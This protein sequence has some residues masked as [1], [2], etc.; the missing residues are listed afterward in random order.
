[1]NTINHNMPAL[2][3][4]NSYTINQE[5]TSH[6]LRKLSSGLKINGARD[7]AALLAISEKMRS[8]TG[9]L[10]RSISNAYDGRNLVQTA[11]GA[12]NQTHS[13][14]QRMRELAVQAANGT[15][16][17][18]DRQQLQ[19]EARQLVGEIDRISDDTEFNTLKLLN[20]SFEKTATADTDSLY[21]AK[22]QLDP[23]SGLATGNYS[24]A[25]SGADAAQAT[26]AVTDRS[27]VISGAGSSFNGGDVTLKDGAAFGSYSLEVTGNGDGTYNGTLTGPDG[28][29]VR[30][31]FSAGAGGA[32]VDF[33]DLSLDFSGVTGL[34]DGSLEI[35]VTGNL[36]FTVAN[37]STGDVSD[38]AFNGYSGGAINLGG[39]QLTGGVRAQ[40]AGASGD[41]GVAVSG[42][43]L[44]LH[45]GANEGQNVRVSLANTSSVSLGVNTVD[46]RTQESANAA[47]GAI[48]EAINKISTERSRMGSATNRM[49]H[50]IRSLAAAET[51]MT[52]SESRIRDADMAKEILDHTKNNILAQASLSIMAQARLMPQGILQLLQ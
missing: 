23:D 38:Y 51:N 47:I 48:D 52:A 7:N 41:V 35:N 27:N 19:A 33:G 43:A 5:N 22:L 17:D 37:Q 9:G 16:S 21:G 15:N 45:V 11:E 8:Q 6:S 14:L 34:S 4:L 18:F 2:N 10:A 30:N 26:A 13:A 31:A 29:T 36:Q 24:V 50:T 1:M 39:I 12:M 44:T 40:A 3:S 42:E 28:N 25:L 46:L 32:N 49:D 20:G